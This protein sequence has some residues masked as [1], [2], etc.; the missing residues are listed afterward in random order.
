LAITI[1]R[2][3]LV[4]VVS[5]GSPQKR[6]PGDLRLVQRFVNSVDF[7]TGEE[8]LETPEGLRSW[9]VERDLMGD[10]EP[11]TGSDL[12]RAVDVREGLR[13]LLLANNGHPLDPGAVERLNGGASRADVRVQFDEHGGPA[14]EPDAAGVDGAMARLMA[15]VARSTH[16]GTWSRLKACLH[17]DCLWA[18]YD[19]SKNRSGKWCRMEEC[20]NVEKARAYRQRQRTASPQ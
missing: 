4:D 18:F 11:V 15:I 12:R 17:D 3:T 5:E 1:N 10:E 2:T 8:E 6:A 9:L 19:H 20:G 14:L 16:D 13:A 7:E